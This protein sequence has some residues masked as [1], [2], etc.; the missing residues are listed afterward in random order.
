[1][2]ALKRDMTAKILVTDLIVPGLAGNCW[3]WRGSH[4][5]AGRARVKVGGKNKQVRRVELERRGVALR[6]SDE[7]FAVCRNAWCVN[8]AHV[9]HGSTEERRA[10][11][12]TGTVDLGTLYAVKTLI[13][14]GKT[15]ETALAEHLGISQRVLAEALRRVS[16]QPCCG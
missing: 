5:G 10:F 8:P 13:N 14:E 15:N 2:E 3:A 11:G 9:L 4:D 1:M 6:C 16:I 7:A 12:K